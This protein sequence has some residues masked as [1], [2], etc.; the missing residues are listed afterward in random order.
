M[1]RHR[2]ALVLLAAWLAAGGDASGQSCP[3]ISLEPAANASLSQPIFVGHAG[4]GTNRLFVVEQWGAIKVIQPGSMVPT[5]FLRIPGA[6]IISGGERGLLGLAFHP[7]F[8]SNRRFFVYYTRS[9][10]GASVIAEYEASAV[11]PNIAE[12]TATTATETVVLAFPQPYANHNGGSLAFGPDGFLYVATGD[13]GSANDPGNYAQNVTLLLGK[14][15]RI[16]VDT[17]NG[18]QKYSSPTDNP[19]FGIPGR[20]EIYA[21]GLRNPWRMS[22]DRLTGQLIAGDVGQSAR[23]E[24]SLITLGGNYGWRVM[25]GTRCNK[26]GDAHPCHWVNFTPPAYEYS[27][28]RG[29]CSVIGGYVYRGPSGA[30]SEGTYVFGDL[31]TGEI[32]GVPLASLPFD[33]SDLPATPTVLRDASFYLTSFG[34]DEAGEVYVTGIGGTVARLVPAVGISPN[35]ESFDEVGGQDT[36]SVT[37]PGSCPSWTAVANVPWITIVSGASGAGNGTV[38]YLVDA[39][40]GVPPRNGTMTIAGRTHDVQQAGGPAPLLTIDDVAVSE[41]PSATASFTVSLSPASANTVSVQYATAA[42]S[43]GGSDFVPVVG[44]VVLDPG[45][46]TKPVLVEVSSDLLDEDDET[47]LVRLSSALKAAIVDGEGTGTIL[48]DDPMPS[49]SIAGATFP[50][51]F[52]VRRVT[53]PVTLSEPSGRAVTVDY[54]VS[55]G[56]AT[57]GEEFRAETGSVSFAPGEIRKRLTVWTKG[58]RTQEA[59]EDFLVGLSGAVNATIAGGPAVG[60]I[61]DDDPPPRPRIVP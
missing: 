2:R 31:C 37:S 35:S 17:P 9:P 22:F 55:P 44:T 1:Q 33:R 26:A 4:D 48:D 40:P 42:A 45:E 6:K 49:V 57:P 60:I 14:I 12:P 24:V 10:D 53:F 38:T 61:V 21:I 52:G 15:L 18:S 51:G 41:G 23:E 34:E 11:D 28:S 30:L 47:F 27:H 59:N 3:A 36:V 43:A 58:D 19:Y 29:R 56:S 50:E 20:D 25:E 8:V 54:T 16:D 46:T 5:L 32:F 7:N 39:N 13:G